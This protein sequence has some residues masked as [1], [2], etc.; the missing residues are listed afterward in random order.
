MDLAVVPW[1]VTGITGGLQ[2]TRQSVKMWRTHTTLVAVNKI[3]SRHII[4]AS[5]QWS[6][7]KRIIIIIFPR[8]CCW[9]CCS[10][11]SR[12]RRLLLMT[13]LDAGGVWDAHTHTLTRRVD[14]QCL[15]PAASVIVKDDLTISDRRRAAANKKCRDVP[16]SPVPKHPWTRPSQAPGLSVPLGRPRS[17]SPTIRLGH[18]YFRRQQQMLWGLAF[19]VEC[20]NMGHNQSID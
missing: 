8:G 7:V 2:W 16:R 6:R 20:V 19:I 3:T 17:R 11:S 15:R 1:C 13:V 4:D 9:C 14:V 10:K 5:E 12:S 18:D